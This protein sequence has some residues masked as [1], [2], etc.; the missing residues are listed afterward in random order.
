MNSLKVLTSIILMNLSFISVVN[1]ATSSSTA[2]L[3][4]VFTPF[5]DPSALLVIDQGDSVVRIPPSLG[6]TS[7]IPAGSHYVNVGTIYPGGTFNV[8]GPYTN[9][10]APLYPNKSLG[11]WVCNGAFYKQTMAFVPGGGNV[12]I[13]IGDYDFIFN[14][15]D[16]MD[17]ETLLGSYTVRTIDSGLAG[18]GQVARYEQG[19]VTGGTG[20]NN[21]ASGGSSSK[22]YVDAYGNLLIRF[23]FD[24]KVKVPQ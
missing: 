9:G 6:I 23:Y 8:N 2:V 7:P 14:S 18:T 4:V 5:V 15:S 10:N 24:N 20:I 17:V 19:L 13:G 16:P 3:D 22:T 21:G 11:T 1:A 12:N